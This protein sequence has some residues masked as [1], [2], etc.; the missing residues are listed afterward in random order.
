MHHHSSSTVASRAATAGASIRTQQTVDKV[1]R[2][3]PELA[4]Q[5]GRGEIT[6]T[7]AAEQYVLSANLHRRQMTAGQQAAIVAS[8]QNWAKAQKH[9]G[10]L[11]GDQVAILPL[12]SIVDRA[13][14]SGEL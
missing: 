14:V 8:M 10:D 3:N 11:K 5:V 1:A 4:A 12:D 13:A 7:K 2:G 6:L 9:S